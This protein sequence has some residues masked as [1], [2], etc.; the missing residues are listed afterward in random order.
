MRSQCQIAPNDFKREYSKRGMVYV[1]FPIED[2]SDAAKEERLAD[3]VCI[4]ENLLDSDHK[5]Y[6]HSTAGVGR[7]VAVGCAYLHWVKGRDLVN[8]VFKEI[9]N[10]RAIAYF[11]STP[12]INSTAEFF[13][14]YRSPKLIEN[15]QE[16]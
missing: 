11:N 10:K 9:K 2:F 7:S 16:S 6:L 8:D 5:V 15:N 14:K 3:A 4:L 13:R 12:I 1:H